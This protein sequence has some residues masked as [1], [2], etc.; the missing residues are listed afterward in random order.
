LLRNR[1]ADQNEKYGKQG[2][3]PHFSQNKYSKE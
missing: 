1:F 2:S 3:E